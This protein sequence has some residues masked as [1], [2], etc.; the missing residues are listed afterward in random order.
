MKRIVFIAAFF[1]FQSHIN[2]N[3]IGDAVEAID[4]LSSVAHHLT[5][6]PKP[7]VETPK[8]ADIYNE[9]STHSAVT[10]GALGALI[11]SLMAN[12]VTGGRAVLAAGAVMPLTYL[13]AEKNEGPKDDF[14]MRFK[15][16]GIG[17]VAAVAMYFVAKPSTAFEQ[18]GAAIMGAG[19][20]ASETGK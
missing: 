3:I 4:T 19:S 2:A 16:V 5:D 9:F 7:A 18:I 1:I 8:P 14:T 6:K 17:A 11:G 20:S 15:Y 12:P 13:I 10:A